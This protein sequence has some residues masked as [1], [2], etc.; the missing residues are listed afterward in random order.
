[1]L[2]NNLAKDTE[3]NNKLIKNGLKTLNSENSD[4]IIDFNFQH[5]IDRNDE[6][7]DKKE[8][9]TVPYLQALRIDKRSYIE[10][11][12][13]V[14]ENEIGF[15][16]IF[17]YKNP[18]S[19]YSLIISVY[20]FELLLDLAMNCFLYTDDVVSEKYHNDG[21]LSMLTS[22]SLSF[23]SNIISSIAVIIIS[24]LTNYHEI[25][26]LMFSYVKDKKK[27]FDNIIRLTKYIKL[28]L[29][30]F[31]FLQLGL[32][33]IMMYYLFIF[34]TVYHQS[35]VSITVNYIIG[36]LTS[37]AISTGLSIIISL[38]RVLSFRY[39]SNIIYNISRYLYDNF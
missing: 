3:S 9:N 27:Y 5:L 33:I 21:S 18:Y 8:I 35:Q 7:I 39:Q 32:I 17:C 12:I 6:D 38:L 23:I 34:C 29:G 1:M 28:R 25:L 11:V 37:L 24:K 10:I 4:L 14:F 31:Y 20:L 26:E 13:S 22:L 19:H 16:N 2:N 30:I 36:A 15:L